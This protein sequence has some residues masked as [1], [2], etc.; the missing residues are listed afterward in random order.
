MGSGVGVYSRVGNENGS[1]SAN[2][3]VSG[4]ENLGVWRE[5][6]SVSCGCREKASA[7]EGGSESDARLVKPSCAENDD[8][9]HLLQQPHHLCSPSLNPVRGPCR[10]DHHQTPDL[11]LVRLRL[12]LFHVLFPRPGRPAA[13]PNGLAYLFH[14]MPWYHLPWPCAFLPFFLR[15]KYEGRR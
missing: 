5:G 9:G 10:C 14:R 4:E 7:F 11:C 8:E 6:E 2:A 3:K 15:R 12:R 1:E 13:R